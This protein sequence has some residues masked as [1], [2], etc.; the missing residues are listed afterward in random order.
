MNDWSLKKYSQTHSSSLFRLN[1][2]PTMPQCFVAVSVVTVRFPQPQ[3]CWDSMFGNSSK[4]VNLRSSS[5]YGGFHVRINMNSTTRILWA[6]LNAG[7]S[8][9]KDCTTRTL[10]ICYNR[11]LLLF[12]KLKLNFKKRS[13]KKSLLTVKCTSVVMMGN[14]KVT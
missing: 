11:I 7:D 14:K 6:I 12:Y 5:V 13:Q 2:E 4:K 8:K 9:S 3:S 10:W 1:F